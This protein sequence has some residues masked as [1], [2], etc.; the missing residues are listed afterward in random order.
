MF[1]APFSCLDHSCREGRLNLVRRRIGEFGRPSL[2]GWGEWK[3]TMQVQKTN[4]G[5]LGLRG[6]GVYIWAIGQT[7]I[8]D[9]GTRIQQSN[10]RRSWYDKSQPLFF[11][12]EFDSC[13][14]LL[15]C[16]KVVR[17]AV[18]DRRRLNFLFAIAASASSEGEE[19]VGG[20][21]RAKKSGCSKLI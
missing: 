3:S 21:G 16:A 12:P 18:S 4:E 1:C 9:K 20:E 5:G 6:W 8:L 2:C 13:S 11:G 10:Q 7:V 15:L 17:G 14:L 19:M